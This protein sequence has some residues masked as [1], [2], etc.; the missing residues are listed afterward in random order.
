MVCGVYQANIFLLLFYCCSFL[1][2]QTS[3]RFEHFGVEEGL[4]QNVVHCI[5]QDSRGFLWIGTHNGLNLY[6]GYEFKKFYHN[7]FDKNSLENNTI[8]AIQEDSMKN[9]WVL[10]YGYL[11]SFDPN[12]ETF[13]NYK[14]PALPPSAS[15]KGGIK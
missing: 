6:D 7:P 8:L 12:T 1:K 3:L 2:A 4:S 15:A 9:I 11:S 14:L 13:K 10:T 5:F